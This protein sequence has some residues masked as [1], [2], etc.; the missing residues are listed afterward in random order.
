MKNDSARD[1]PTDPRESHAQARIFPI[2]DEGL[3]FSKDFVLDICP[4]ILQILPQLKH[5]G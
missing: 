4:P 3:H 2:E 1:S 5:S